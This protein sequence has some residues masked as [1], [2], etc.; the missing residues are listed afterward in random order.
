MFLVERLG[1]EGRLFPCV[2]FV[3][4]DRSDPAF[5]AGGMIGFA[6]VALVADRGARIEVRT[7]IEKRLEARRAGLLAA[8]QI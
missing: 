8:G 6:V 2:G 5:A 3:G 7:K 4:D 1:E